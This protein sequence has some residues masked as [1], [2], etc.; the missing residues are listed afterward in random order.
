MG[1]LKKL[2]LAN[3]PTPIQKLTNI[4]KE[5]G[6]DIYIKRD[7]L[8]GGETSGNKIRKLEYTVA[9]AI[10]E[11]A[12]LL[13]TCGGIQSNHCRATAAVAAKLGLRS[14]L[15]LRIDEEPPVEGNYLLDKILGAEIT[16]ISRAD[17][18]KRRAEIMQ[19]IKEEYE[20]Q[21]IKAY[22]IP[23]GASDGIGNI[24]YLESVK[25]IKKQ[26]EELGISF[27]TIVCAVGSGSTYGGLFLG[28]KLYDPE[29]TVLGFN[30]CDDEQYFLDVCTRICRETVELLGKNIE[31]KPEDMHIVDGHKG[32]GYAI[33]TDEELAFLIKLAR[34]EGLILDPVYTGKAFYGLY[35]EIKEGKL[36][37]LGNVLF[38]HTGGVFGLF[39]KQEQLA[40]VL[41]A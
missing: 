3:L 8:T 40:E 38:I 29:K 35:Q 34:E 13:I 37:D 18:S 1:D 5:L 41:E 27:Q 7:D 17:Y 9:K 16:F 26:E 28:T 10:D 14:H 31:I 24:G 15:V 33:S 19:N 22:V 36:K 4:S 20:K 30:V 21:G 39:P 11:G 25:E 6:V 32:I 12:Q 23:E 2:N